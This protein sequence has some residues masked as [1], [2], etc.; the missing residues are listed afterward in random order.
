MT[1][2]KNEQAY[3]KAKDRVKK[4]KKFYSHLSVYII[5]NIALFL[6][7][8]NFR[9]DNFGNWNS[10]STWNLFSTP[11]LWGIGLLIHG[12]VVFGKIPILGK[13]WEDRKIKELM[14]KDK[15]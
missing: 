2:Y 8:S 13:E 4:E 10:W 7:N 6:I 9:F 15:F 3:Q 5:I 12:I 11:V 1:D 14:D